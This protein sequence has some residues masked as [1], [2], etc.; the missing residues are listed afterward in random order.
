[1][2]CDVPIDATELNG[3]DQQVFLLTQIL[4]TRYAMGIRPVDS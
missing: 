1:M 2:I 3:I 4:G